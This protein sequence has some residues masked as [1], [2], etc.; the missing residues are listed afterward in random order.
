MNQ[1][2]NVQV[3]A[4]LKAEATLLAERLGVPLSVVITAV[5]RKFVADK[6]IEIREYAFDMKK[7]TASSEFE[8][9]EVPSSD[10][11]VLAIKGLRDSGVLKQWM[12]DMLKTQYNSPSHRITSMDLAKQLGYKR[13]VVINRWYGFIGKKVANKMNFSYEEHIPA[14]I[15]ST[16]IQEMVSGYKTPQYILTMRPEVAQALKELKIV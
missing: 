6:G 3:E 5:L 8:E 7:Q 16:F 13:F 14:E 10:K 15:L 4:S 12:I 1:V 11:F 9:L 2:I